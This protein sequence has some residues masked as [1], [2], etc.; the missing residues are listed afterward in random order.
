MLKSKLQS[1]AEAK[2]TLEELVT[3]K[4]A[5]DA[6]HALQEASLSER[7]VELEGQLQSEKLAEEREEESAAALELLR[8]KVTALEEELRAAGGR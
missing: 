8:Q 5:A 2:A 4:E 3:V 1:A 6:S 7:I